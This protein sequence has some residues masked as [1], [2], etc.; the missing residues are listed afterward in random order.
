MSEQEAIGRSLAQFQ[1]W[2]K[3]RLEVFQSVEGTRLPVWE[4][5]GVFSPRRLPVWIA[6][7]LAALLFLLPAFR[8]ALEIV[9]VPGTDPETLDSRIFSERELRRLEQSGDK[10][11]YARAL[12][13]M[14][15][16][17][18]EEEG[19]AA[20]RAAEKAI[21]LDPGLTWISAKFSHASRS[22]RGYD[23]HPWIER[24]KAWD[25]QNVF[26][27]LLEAD[28]NVHWWEARWTKY[29]ATPGG[30]SQALGA[31]PG[32]RIPM[33][34]VFAAPRLDFYHAE[35]FAL[36][37]QVLE[38]QGFE[39]PDM[40][41][42][43]ALSRPIP[44]LMTIDFYARLELRGIGEAEEKAGRVDEALASYWSVVHFADRLKATPTDVIQA[45]ANKLQRDAYARLLPLLASKGR[46]A[47]AKAIESALA[48]LPRFDYN[49]RGPAAAFLEATARRSARLI[50][51]SAVFVAVLGFLT[52]LWLA[53]LMALRCQLNSDTLSR[54]F[55]RLA[56][57]LSFAPPALLVASM[58]VFLGYYPYARSIGEMHSYQEL[59]HGYV[60]V[61]AGLYHVTS[62]GLNEVLVSHMFWPSIWSAFVALFGLC[63]L[64]WV[65]HR[66]RPDDVA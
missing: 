56:S 53:S 42:A 9:L 14:A 13:F 20:M 55:D 44:D 8:Q 23:P 63:L 47:E 17:S 26:P 59:E 40:L 21:A 34:R 51:V 4:Q 15:L 39:R 46:T 11:K 38:E 49:V 37:R 29:A 52:A 27:Y 50:L 30:L 62:F 43:A 19:L 57:A 1:D 22:S 31:E 2:E 12:A 3:L 61:L 35:R 58:A 54:G 7:G 25:P 65:R 10:E 6:L 32:W 28:A 45:G 64:W 66:E 24:L 18:S 41:F 16:D 36:D 33:E 48:L 5:N 60:P